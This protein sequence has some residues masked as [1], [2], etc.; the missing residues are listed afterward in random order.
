MNWRELTDGERHA[1]GLAVFHA[2]AVLMALS[3]GQEVIRGGS[4]ITP[5]LY[6]PS[7]YEIPALM[8]VVV[9]AASAGISV[10]GC[11]IGGRPGAGL[12]LVGG[13]VSGAMYSALAVLASEAST[14]TLLVAGASYITAPISFLGALLAARHIRRGR[15]DGTGT[16]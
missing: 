3:F 11:V 4:P 10:A 6:G 12:A 13:L 2:G 8:W 16:C 9:Q 14:G 15:D 7:V 1:P 5:E